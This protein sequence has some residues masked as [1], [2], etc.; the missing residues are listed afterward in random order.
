MTEYIAMD[1]TGVFTGVEKT[2]MQAQFEHLHRDHYQPNFGASP[3]E[4]Y[5]A[6][7]KQYG[8][9]SKEK[10]S[11]HALREWFMTMGDVY[12]MTREDLEET[13]D[14]CFDSG[15]MN[16]GVI[17]AVIRLAKEHGKKIIIVSKNPKDEVSYV[18]DRINEEAGE[19]VI[20]GVIGT[21]L[22]YDSDGRIIGVKELEYDSDGRIIGVKRLI[23]DSGSG[24]IDDTELVLKSEEIVRYA[25]SYD[26]VSD[27]KDIDI[28][29]AAVAAGNKAILIRHTPGG[30][31]RDPYF[32][33][34]EDY[35]ESTIE[36]GAYN[37][38]VEN[39]GNVEDNLVDMLADNENESE[40]E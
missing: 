33:R 13:V 8:A 24:D 11:D 12:G 25:T 5:L 32:A 29:E 34:S 35:Q 16:Q 4:D 6:V 37:E 17:D 36:S 30:E 40:S 1:F 15:V 3:L 18:A 31:E 27:E 38:E 2:T 19:E 26:F 23:S 21:E 20:Y 22:E 7:N 14:K 39:D 10:S 9:T 28:A